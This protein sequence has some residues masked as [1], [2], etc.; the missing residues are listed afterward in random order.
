[1]ATVTVTAASTETSRL[2]A[3]TRRPA[4]RANS[5]SWATANRRGASPT[6]TVMTTT[7]RTVV[8]TRSLVLTVAIEPKR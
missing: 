7:A 3:R 8:I 2:Y 1:M 4:T 6:A 5:G